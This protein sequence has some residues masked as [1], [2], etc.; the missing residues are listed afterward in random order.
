[1]DFSIIVAMDEHR[2]IGKNNQLPWRLPGELKH[3]KEIT[4]AP[5]GEG[6][7]N[8]VIMGRKT[9]DSLPEKFRPL[10]NRINVV[11]TRD[12]SLVFPNNVLKSESLESALAQL[13]K[14][15]SVGAV[16]VI[17]GAQVFQT[18]IHH[19]NCRKLY[20]TQ[21]Q[22]RFE[23]DTFFSDFSQ[24]YKKILTSVAIKEGEIS[25]FFEEFLRQ[26]S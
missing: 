20:I 23:C 4:C 22:K 7:Q 2:G 25:Y 26:S 12:A 10:P 15:K 1:M 9:W 18:A 19:P 8:A 3:F 21:I 14:L 24:N 6:K 5:A 17:G 13:A 11:I 16:F